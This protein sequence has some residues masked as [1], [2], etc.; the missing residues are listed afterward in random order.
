MKVLSIKKEKVAAPDA[1]LLAP[2]RIARTQK[3][4]AVETAPDL[5][6]RDSTC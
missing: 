5:I 2:N 6:S 3:T 4:G 1:A